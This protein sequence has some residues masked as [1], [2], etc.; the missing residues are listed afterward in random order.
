MQEERDQIGFFSVVGDHS[1]SKHRVLFFFICEVKFRKNFGY[2][3]VVLTAAGQELLPL[4]ESP[5]ELTPQPPL[6]PEE[7]YRMRL[8]F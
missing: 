5:L 2:L 3:L 6:F 1:D 4:V 7:N 8:I